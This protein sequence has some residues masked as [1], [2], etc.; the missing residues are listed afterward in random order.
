[1][2]GKFDITLRNKKDAAKIQ[3]SETLSLSAS[4]DHKKWDGKK[5]KSKTEI[6]RNLFNAKVL[7][8]VFLFAKLQ[9]INRKITIES[10][11]YIAETILKEL[12]LEKPKKWNNLAGIIKLRDDM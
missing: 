3:N 4:S 11:P 1:M 10:K 7:W 5:V 8:A 9:R 6:A 12:R 2:T